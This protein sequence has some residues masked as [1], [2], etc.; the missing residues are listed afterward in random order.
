M[1]WY[2]CIYLEDLSSMHAHLICLWCRDES[3]GKAIVAVRLDTAEGRIGRDLFKCL[4]RDIVETCR[5]VFGDL[6]C[7]IIWSLYLKAEKPENLGGV[8]SCRGSLRSCTIL[9]WQRLRAPSARI[10]LRG[11]IIVENVFGVK[12]GRSSG[13][14]M[15]SNSSICLMAQLTLHILAGFDVVVRICLNAV[16]ICRC[17]V[18]FSL[19]ESSSRFKSAIISRRSLHFA[20]YEHSCSQWLLESGIPHSRLFLVS[21]RCSGVRDSLF[22]LLPPWCPNLGTRQLHDSRLYCL[23]SKSCVAKY[24]IISYPDHIL[25]RTSRW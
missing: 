19:H 11:R 9:H 17:K 6:S 10:L 13:F 4:A 22:T 21:T 14:I 2:C 12:K 18:D 3:V 16:R 25:Q 20:P 7:F 8:D 1:S 23:W 24:D 5:I 15:F